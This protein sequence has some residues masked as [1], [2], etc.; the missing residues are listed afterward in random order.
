ML[1]HVTMTALR[2]LY[3]DYGAV[4]EGQNFT[5]A[6]DI[7]TALEARGLARRVTETTAFHAPENKMLRVPENKEPEP[8][9]TPAPV[10]VEVI[11]APEAGAAPFRQLHPAD[12]EPPAVAQESHRL[13]PVADIPAVRTAHPGIRTRRAG[14]SR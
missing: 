13:L 1:Y 11:K 14:R 5:T 7:A 9:H 12:A 4:R 8:A 6:S 2:P 3:G 10:P